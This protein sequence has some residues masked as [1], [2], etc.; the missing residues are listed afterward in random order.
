MDAYVTK[1]LNPQEFF[2]TIETCLTPTP[3]PKGANGAPT[4]LAHSSV[5]EGRGEE[6]SS[7]S[8]GLLTSVSMS[9]PIDVHALLARCMGS[10]TFLE[11]M[12]NK[13]RDQGADAL[14]QIVSAVKAR[15][16]AATARAAHALKGAAANLAADGVCAAAAGI[17]AQARAAQ[18]DAAEQ[19]LANLR[20]QLERCLADIPDAVTRAAQKPQTPT[21]E[22]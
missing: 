17:E 15:D 2:E 14:D 3:S 10:T 22:P 6:R 9:R 11:K 19:A 16:A 8:A 18:L 5:R 4:Q 7:P 20:A 13:F 1:P 12:L 21:P